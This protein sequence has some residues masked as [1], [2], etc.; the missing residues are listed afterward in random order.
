MARGAPVSS[1]RLVECCWGDVPPGRPGD[2]LSV[3]VSRLR[4]VIGRDRIPLGDGGYRLIADWLDLDA[5]EQLALEARRRL[6]ERSPTAARAAA[7]AALALVRGPLLADEPDAEWLPAERR[8]CERVVAGVMQV[9]AEASAAV[10]DQLG[11]IDAASR[12]L[13]HDPYDEVALRTLMTAYVARGRPA[14]ALSEYARVRT[15]LAEDLG[16][17]PTPETEAL[18]TAI[19]RGDSEPASAAEPAR[20]G[21]EA[22]IPVPIPPGRGDVLAGLDRATAVPGPVL[23]ELEGEAGI[24]KTRVLEAWTDRIRRRHVTVLSARCAELDRALPLQVML[25]ALSAGL[26]ELDDAGAATM[27]G[28]DAALLA[29]LLQRTEDATDGPVGALADAETGRLAL[30]AALLAVV[31]RLAERTPVVLVLDDAHLAGPAT[32]DWLHYL[33]THLGSEAVSVV[34]ARRPGEGLTIDADLTIELGPLDHESVA[35]IVGSDRAE[36]LFARSGGHPLFLVELADADDDSVLPSSIVASVRARCERAG[37]SGE[38]LRTAAIIGSTIDLDLLAAVTQESPV[39]L[40]GHLEDGVQRRFLL[41]RNAAFVFAHDLIR[42][43]LV[44]GTSATRRALVHREA[45]RALQRRAEAE[46]LDVAFHARLGG[47]RALA[48]RAY[49]EAASLAMERFDHATAATLLDQAIELH[50]VA[51]AR[52]QRARVA[53]LM[54]RYDDARIHADAA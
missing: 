21:P 15:R 29:P 12:A 8:A 35:E 1:D 2:Q 43:A 40:L 45:S 36:A 30:F 34:A 19:L 38:T 49:A 33:R 22:S 46:P 3:L 14:S 6:A 50:D 25:D 26:R 9:A 20:E 17:D 52:V 4:G 31:R 18:H 39:A 5:V 41:E 10:G 23:I 24:G 47:D 53:I 51:A 54:G 28:P 13:E 48:A 32:I 27:L 16:V 42:D 7:D 37:A 44:E 11:A